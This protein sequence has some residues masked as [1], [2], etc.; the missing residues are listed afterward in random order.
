[1]KKIKCVIGITFFDE[2]KMLWGSDIGEEI[3]G[4]KKDLL[5]TVWGNNKGISRI[6]AKVLSL[7]IENFYGNSVNNR[8][9]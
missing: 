2:E 9:Y 5:C 4:V 1:V 6:N 3:D 7:V 8:T